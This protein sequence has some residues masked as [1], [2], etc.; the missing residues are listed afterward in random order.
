MEGKIS[1]KVMGLKFMQ[2][3][4][5]RKLVE[6]AAAK[7]KEEATEVRM[8]RACALLALE[9]IQPPTD[10]ST[11][12]HPAP[13]AGAWWCSRAAATCPLPP[14]GGC[15][16]GA[17]RR[18]PS[19]RTRAARRRQRR[20]TTSPPARPMSGTRRW[21]KGEGVTF[22]SLPSAGH[23]RSYLYSRLGKKEKKKGGKGGHGTG[24]GGGGSELRGKDKEGKRRD[25][26]GDGPRKKKKKVSK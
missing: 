16:S 18:G 17:S 10:R 25:G 2:R 5:E 13:P 1:S 11:G 3:A 8:Q 20:M 21:Q 6:D 4:A 14:A 7:P 22:I 26:A 9:L 12:L 24:G 23:S 15:R 19:L